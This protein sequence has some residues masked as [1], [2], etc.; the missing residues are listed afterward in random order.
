MISFIDECALTVIQDLVLDQPAGELF[1][2]EEPQ[3]GDRF[4]QQSLMFSQ[5][6]LR[7]LPGGPVA[8]HEDEVGEVGGL[9]LLLEDGVERFDG[10]A[11][12]TPVRSILVLLAGDEDERA[13]GRLDQ[14][15]NEGFEL[16]EGDEL[17]HLDLLKN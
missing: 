14:L 3:S 1:A 9:G 8:G 2:I 16:G 4:H 12:G 7:V 15:L 6:V 5:F 11:V 10:L 17:C 13:G